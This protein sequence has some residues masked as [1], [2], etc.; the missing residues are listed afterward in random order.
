MEE[1]GEKIKSLTGN[2]AV[3]METARVWSPRKGKASRSCTGSAREGSDALRGSSAWQGDL[4]CC[5]RFC[6]A[7]LWAADLQR[8]PWRELLPWER[9]Q[10]RCPAG[11]RQGRFT[12]TG[13]AVLVD[14]FGTA[15]SPAPS[16]QQ[17]LSSLALLTHQP[18]FYFSALS[19]TTTFQASLG[20]GLLEQRNCA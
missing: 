12:D 11:A 7:L 5:H 16:L 6:Q 15:Q 9:A 14:G 13:R 19:P 4:G 20:N 1:K 8:T 3:A 10:V 2:K 17:G 18:Y